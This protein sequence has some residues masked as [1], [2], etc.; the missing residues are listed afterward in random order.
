MAIISLEIRPIKF[1]NWGKKP[2]CCLPASSSFEYVL[3]IFHGNLH[4]FFSPKYLKPDLLLSPQPPFLPQKKLQYHF[5][6]TTLSPH[7]FSLFLLRFFLYFVL[8]SLFARLL[9]GISLIGKW[10]DADALLDK[11]HTH[12]KQ[13][14]F[15]LLEVRQPYIY[16]HS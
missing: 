3:P 6:T 9:D 2:S 12:S 16:M 1:L 14:R 7:F 5:K 15:S 8:S 11:L 4:H 10:F 13:H